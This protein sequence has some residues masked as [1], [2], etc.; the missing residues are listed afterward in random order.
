MF[1][2]MEKQKLCLNKNL[3]SQKKHYDFNIAP[4][5][6]LEHLMKKNMLLR[7][8]CHKNKIGKICFKLV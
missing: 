4:N 3:T 1:Q 5:Q 7:Y 6:K 8:Y 2:D